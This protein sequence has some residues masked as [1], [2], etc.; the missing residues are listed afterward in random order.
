MKK[1]FFVKVGNCYVAFL[2]LWHEPK[3]VSDY[4]KAEPFW[5]E[6]EAK[7]EAVRRGVRDFKV[8]EKIL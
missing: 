3:M 5:T 6:E 1:R 8:V 2:G 4:H 7:T